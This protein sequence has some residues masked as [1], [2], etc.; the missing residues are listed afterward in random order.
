MDAIS[1]KKLDERRRVQSFRCS[2]FVHS[3]L[4]ATQVNQEG[5]CD[6]DIQLKI[7]YAKL[8]NAICCG[9]EPY[10]AFKMEKPFNVYK[11][12]DNN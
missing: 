9:L 2:L 6:L 11:H 12:K 8:D 4:D 1:I 5:D 3:F 10:H 7:V